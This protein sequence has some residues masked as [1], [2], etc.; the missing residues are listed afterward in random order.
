MHE[1]SLEAPTYLFVLYPL[2]FILL[3]LRLQWFVSQNAFRQRAYIR[4]LI[5]CQVRALNAKL[6]ALYSLIKSC[7]LKF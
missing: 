1:I 3:R 7:Y 4:C 6:F 5:Y 2:P